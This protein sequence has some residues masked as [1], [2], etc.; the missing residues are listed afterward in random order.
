MLKISTSFLAMIIIVATS[1]YLVQFPINDWLT[2][3]A[4]T[5]PISFLVT[6]LTNRFHGPKTAR[7]V[8]YAGFAAAVLLSIG[9]ATPKIAFASG[10]AFLVSQ[11]LD[12]SVFNRLRQGPWWYAP[13]FAS[14]TASI[15]DN[16]LFWSIAFWGEDLPVLTWALGDLSIKLL[17][18]LCMLTPFRMAIRRTS[19][20][21]ASP[22][23]R[24]LG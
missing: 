23:V 10:L 8:V 20:S 16:S 17:L 6:E 2:F 24:P 22:Q 18:D 11:L 14:L 4:L 7:K 5:Y 21:A 19:K 3:G 13:F 12:I 1:N 9:L 15:V